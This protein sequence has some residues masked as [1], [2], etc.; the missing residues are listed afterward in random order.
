MEGSQTPPPDAAP[1]ADGMPN[2]AGAG[3]RIATVVLAFALALICAV[4]IAVMGDVA[5]KG[6]CEDIDLSQTSGLYECYD[7][8]ASAEPIVLAAGWI[9]AILA[10]VAAI[11]ALAF[12]IRGRGGRPLLFVTA[13]AAGFLVLSIIVAQL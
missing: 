10:G 12:T 7:F 6:V 5:D 9:G 13:A 2:T 1:S 8:S 3:A 4:G 11:M